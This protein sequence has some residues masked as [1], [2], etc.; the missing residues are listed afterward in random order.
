MNSQILGLRVATIIFGLMSLAQL[1]RLVIQPEV[2]VAGHQMHALAERACLG[3]RWPEYVAIEAFP[4][5]AQMRR[6]R[7]T[8]VVCRS[9]SS[10]ARACSSRAGL[11]LLDSVWL[12]DCFG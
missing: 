3:D 5:H 12:L 6:S 1:L 8:P 11:D 2:L 7:P 9:A 4:D 10:P